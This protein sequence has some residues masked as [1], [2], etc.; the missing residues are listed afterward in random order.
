VLL[1]NNPLINIYFSL[2]SRMFEL[3]YLL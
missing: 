2:F 1:T 3:S